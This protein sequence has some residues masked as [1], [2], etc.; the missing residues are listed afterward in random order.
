MFSV[1][2]FI[3][4]YKKTMFPDVEIFLYKC[5]TNTN[6]NLA[7]IDAIYCVM[8]STLFY[9]PQWKKSLV[10]LSDFPYI[11]GQE[12]PEHPSLAGPGV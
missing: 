1:N 4:G 11:A 12:W 10:S 8:T 2:Y 3:Y 6:S 7:K 5:I 9:C